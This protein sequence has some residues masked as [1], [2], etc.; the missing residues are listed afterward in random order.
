MFCS[1]RDADSLPP[2]RGEE[3]VRGEGFTNE[4]GINL[5]AN[6][7]FCEANLWGFNYSPLLRLA[8][9]SKTAGDH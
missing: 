9:K 1:N 3:G 4:R 2:Q 7:S 5:P 6:A 8:A